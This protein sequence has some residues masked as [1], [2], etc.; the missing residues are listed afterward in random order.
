MYIYIYIYIYIYRERERERE[1]ERGRERL[2]ERER[3]SKRPILHCIT[4]LNKPT[5]PSAALCQ[6]APTENA[7]MRKAEKERCQQQGVFI[8]FFFLH[9]KK[10]QQGV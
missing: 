5:F 4:F 1:R 10:T 9:A 6:S 7:R 8:F 3:V 2:R